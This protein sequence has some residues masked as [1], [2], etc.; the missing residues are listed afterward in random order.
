M[1]MAVR[2]LGT[3]GYLAPERRSGRP[4]TVQS[5]LYAVGRLVEA[6]TGAV[7]IPAGPDR[8]LHRPPEVARRAPSPRPPAP[9]HVGERDAAT[10]LRI[11]I[12]GS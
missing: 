3:P 1:T 6:I 12:I 8:G 4:A 7:S 9:V 10:L 2:V 5:D 11:F